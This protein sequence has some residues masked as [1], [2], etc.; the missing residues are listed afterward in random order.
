MK[1]LLTIALALCV[2]TLLTANA[3]IQPKKEPPSVDWQKLLADLRERFAKSQEPTLLQT[4]L[5]RAY[6]SLNEDDPDQAPILHFKGVCLRTALDDDKKMK[7]VLAKELAGVKLP[8]V[9]PVVKI[10]EITFHDSPI[11]SLQSAAV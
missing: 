10:D 8:G 3:H 6:F 1:H 9:K 7:D 2:G 11:Y 5:D 4:R